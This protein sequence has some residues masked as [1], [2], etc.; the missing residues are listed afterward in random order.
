MADG[1]DQIAAASV[2]TVRP[3]KLWRPYT[4]FFHLLTHDEPYLL[5]AGTRLSRAPAG[6]VKPVAVTGIG[7][8]A[9]QH[10]A[11]TRRRGEFVKADHDSGPR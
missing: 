3:R 8:Q 5:P 1:I 4:M 7:F 11:G 6:W 9:A 10:V 2:P